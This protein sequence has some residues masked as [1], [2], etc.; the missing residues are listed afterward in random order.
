MREGDLE[1]VFKILDA[2]DTGSSEYADFCDELIQLQGQDLQIVMA[3]T[4]LNVHEID[5]AVS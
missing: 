1:P 3:M 2:A 5:P 4:R